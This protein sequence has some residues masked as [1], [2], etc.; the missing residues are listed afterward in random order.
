M[1]SFADLLSKDKADILC[2]LDDGIDRYLAII[3]PHSVAR[4][5]R[6]I[7]KLCLDWNNEDFLS[8]FAAR[9]DY[10]IP[11]V[12]LNFPPGRSTRS[13][14]AKTLDRSGAGTYIKK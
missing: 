13:A 3:P 14:S 5:D 12:E 9:R 8:P 10:D 6:S 11:N 2:Y 7:W 4:L 1:L